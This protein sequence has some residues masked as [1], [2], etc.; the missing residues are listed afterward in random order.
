MRAKLIKFDY[1]FD[2]STWKIGNTQFQIQYARHRVYDDLLERK[3]SKEQLEFAY[4]QE[5]KRDKDFKKRED[6][7]KILKKEGIEI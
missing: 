6:K 3:V 4:K 7:I 1:A 2:T 5:I